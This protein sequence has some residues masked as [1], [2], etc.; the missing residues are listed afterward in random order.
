MTRR[1]Q[2]RLRALLG[3]IAALCL[4]LGIRH[5]LDRYGNRIDV[6]DAKV[7]MPIKVKATCFSPFGPSECLLDVGYEDES[8]GAF[9]FVAE[10]SWLCLYS[11]EYELAPVDHPCRVVVCLDQHRAGAIHPVKRQVIEVH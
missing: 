9:G 2:F 8:D 6:D 11:V 3:T 1:F 10:R 4:A 7:G 5:L